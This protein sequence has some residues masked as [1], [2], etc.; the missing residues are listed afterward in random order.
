MPREKQKTSLHSLPGGF[1]NA[2]RK[3]EILPSPEP[4]KLPRC[5]WSQHLSAQAA[6]CGAP[7]E[8]LVH[9]GTDKR[10]ICRIHFQKIHENYWTAGESMPDWDQIVSIKDGTLVTVVGNRKKQL[11]AHSPK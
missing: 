8:F 6:K 11:P 3:I 2:D 1:L 4:A 10:P 9:S 7:A 5:D